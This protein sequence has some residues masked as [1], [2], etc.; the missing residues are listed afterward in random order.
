[1]IGMIAALVAGVLL[2][3]A[4]SRGEDRQFRQMAGAALALHVVFAFAQYWVQEAFYGISDVHGFANEAEPLVRAL[5]LDFARFFPEVVKLAL[6][7]D[8]NLPSTAGM[9]GDPNT[10]MAALTALTFFVVGDSLLPSFV[11]V[12]VVN[13]VGS[14]FLA[15]ALAAEVDEDER[16]IA[17]VAALLVPSVVYWSSAIV[18]EGFVMAGLGLLCYSARRTI[19]QREFYLVPGM[20]VGGAL[21]GLIKP[22]V[23]FPLVIAMGAWAFVGR[24]NRRGT[25]T[26]RVGPLVIAASLAIAG[27]LIMGKLF[28][29]FSVSK[30]GEHTA[31]QQGLWENQAATSAIELGG[32]PSERSLI[33]QLP[34][35]PVALV[36]TLF[37]PVF[38]EVRNVTMLAAALEST[39]LTV[40]VAS[41]LWR[42]RFGAARDAVMRS[43]LMAASLTFALILSVGVGLTTLNLGTL[44]R[45]RLPMMPFYVL[46][47]GLL[48]VRLRRA[49]ERG[50]RVGRPID[51]VEPGD[52]LPDTDPTNP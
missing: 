30:I 33:A 37:R 12:S 25:P 24:L 17:Y 13:W 47:V 26:L 23:L 34:F 7:L 16:P 19:L 51:D 8:A 49:A 27:L 4:L 44:S 45:Y 2:L 32:T 21:I 11:V 52:G 42:F 43:P 50:A 40:V 35:V 5:H 28:P 39:F 38:F 20:L 15:K 18:K 1:M 10:T 22:Y 46:C 36:N 41:T 3:L 31:H 48:S 9:Q 29:E 14:V 6:H